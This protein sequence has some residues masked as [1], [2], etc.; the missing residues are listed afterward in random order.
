VGIFTLHVVLM[1]LFVVVPLALVRAGLPARDHWWLYLSVLVAG[2]V[3]ML[4]AVIGPVAAHVRKV[5]LGAIALLGAGLVVLLV[6]HDSLA[7]LVAALVIFFTA[8]N[9]LE[10]KLPALVSRAAPAGARGAATGVYSTVQFL[11]T[12]VGGAVG[13]FLAQHLG[14]GT[15]IGAC[16][17]ATGAWLAVA[18]KMGDSAPISPEVAANALGAGTSAPPA[19]T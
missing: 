14:D 2:V 10:A 18:W 9:V 1:A 7:G 5:F 12:F 13:G 3:L 6:G 15:V 19:S 11:G 16:L 4:P 17:A 8:F